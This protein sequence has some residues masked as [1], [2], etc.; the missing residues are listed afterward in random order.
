MTTKLIDSFKTY[1]RL[2]TISSAALAV[3]ATH[4]QGALALGAYHSN[5][6]LTQPNLGVLG[7]EFVLFGPA[8]STDSTTIGVLGSNTVTLTINGA[9]GSGLS[10]L[11]G[12]IAPFLGF[13][14]GYDLITLTLG[15]LTP[16]AQYNVAA[17]SGSGGN[18]TLVSLPDGTSGTL[19]SNNNGGTSYVEANAANNFQGNYIMNIQTADANGN[20]LITASLPGSNPVFSGVGISVVPEPSTYLLLGQASSWCS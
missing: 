2:L 9:G 6:Q 10:Y 8:G 3:S 7:E 14:Y 15:G 1:A 11:S 16:N 13:S 4:S 5:Q 20:I 12:A 19:S 17:Y 18:L